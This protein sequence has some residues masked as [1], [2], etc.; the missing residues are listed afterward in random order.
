M[1]ERH[2]PST[3]VAQDSL[4][5]EIARICEQAA[6]IAQG[7]EHLGAQIP[8]PQS[9]ELREL[10]MAFNNLSAALHRNQLELEQRVQDRILALEGTNQELLREIAEGKL[11]AEI[12]FSEGSEEA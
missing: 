2:P 10:A 5:A 6:Q 1:N 7:G 12:S 8:L 9:Q 3:H 4:T 11:I